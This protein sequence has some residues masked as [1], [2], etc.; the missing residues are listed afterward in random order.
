LKARV[1]ELGTDPA[2]GLSTA[3]GVGGARIERFLGR[4]IRRSEDVAADFVDDILGPISLKG[5]IPSSGRPEGLAKA[6]IKD[7][8]F[9]TATKALFVD[10]RGL[11]PEAAAQVR[12]VVEEGAA[13]SS[14]AIFFLD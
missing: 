7:A 4:P 13:G 9:N 10:L 12:S 6:A 1:R 11:S 3:E 5:P 14:K 2:T 8:R